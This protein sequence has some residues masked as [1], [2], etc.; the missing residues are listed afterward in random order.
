MVEGDEKS[1][2][3]LVSKASANYS[4]T[5]GNIKR[6]VH[7]DEIVMKSGDG[8]RITKTVTEERVTRIQDSLS[9]SRPQNGVSPAQSHGSIYGLSSSTSQSSIGPASTSHSS[10]FGLSPSRGHGG[11]SPAQSQS[12]LYGLSSSTSQTSVISGEHV[13][14]SPNRSPLM[15]KPPS[16]S[17]SSER[18]SVL[19][20]KSKSYQPD[21]NIGVESNNVSSAPI[22]K[23]SRLFKPT[24]TVTVKEPTRT[25]TVKETI[26]VD[27]AAK[28]AESKENEDPIKISEQA[29]WEARKGPESV[30]KFKLENFGCNTFPRS[31]GRKQSLERVDDP[32][33]P[34]FE[35][36]KP[37]WRAPVENVPLAPQVPPVPPKPVSPVPPPMSYP[38]ENQRPA[39]THFPGMIRPPA[40]NFDILQLQPPPPPPPMPPAM[41]PPPT[42]PKPKKFRPGST[43]TPLAP[44]EEHHHH[45]RP[46]HIPVFAPKVYFAPEDDSGFP[47]SPTR[48]D[49]MNIGDEHSDVSSL[50]MTT[51]SKLTVHV[52]TYLH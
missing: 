3:G 2:P 31:Y 48:S 41:G 42:A 25:V 22:A 20:E 16:Q 23:P 8:K 21:I 28:S 19:Q 17:T 11:L 9:P 49:S 1:G 18:S 7:T 51:R 34:M 30:P 37:S 6:D 10:S 35:V 38:E 46:D 13:G 27:K 47:G 32:R 52:V 40:Q 15:W 50:T 43:S 44:E 39:H 29:K 45:H 4:T 26:V 12:S 24:K 36:Y 14:R 5:E 33:Y